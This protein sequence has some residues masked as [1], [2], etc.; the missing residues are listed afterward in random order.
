MSF[1]WCGWMLFFFSPSLF[2]AET[3]ESASQFDHSQE[4]KSLQQTTS[5]DLKCF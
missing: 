3:V 2:F 5:I 1:C 4:V